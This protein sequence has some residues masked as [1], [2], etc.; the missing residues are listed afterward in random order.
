MGKRVYPRV[1]GFAYDAA[2]TNKKTPARAKRKT[3]AKLK[4]QLTG[5]S[6]KAFLEGIDDEG[7]RKDAFEVLALMKKVTK[8]EPKMWGTAIVGFGD[9]HYESA[10][11]RSGEW[12]EAGFSPRKAALTIYLVGGV[13]RHAS[14]I[15]SLGKVK[16]SGGS[17]GGCL[18]I[19]RLADVD[20]GVLSRLIGASVASLPGRARRS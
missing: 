13:Q 7:R 16:T 4:T 11:G 5:K 3:V 19:R 14:M 2:M 17:L 10:S 1:S 8:R 18:Y 6:V 9:Y 20:K 15:E 12:F